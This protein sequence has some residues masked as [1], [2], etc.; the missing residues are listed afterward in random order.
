MREI[1][2][3][4]PDCVEE[5]MAKLNYSG[6]LD[7]IWELVKEANRYLEESA[8]WALA[9]DEQTIPRMRAVLYNALEAVR[10]V[11]LFTAPTM[12]NTSAEVFRR[13]SLGAIADV[14]NLHEA[15]TWGQLPVG[16]ATVKGDPLFPRIIEE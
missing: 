9:A 4:L 12:P 7:G 5:R 2:A 15:V 16:N 14:D 8:P 3:T 11:A 6:A 13:L 1:A 10:I